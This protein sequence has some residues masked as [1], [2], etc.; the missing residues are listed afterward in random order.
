MRRFYLIAAA[1]IGIAVLCVSAS[2]QQ[3]SGDY[4]ETRSADVYTG[5]CVANGEVNLVGDQA[6]LGWKVNQGVWNGTRL[7]GL[8][9][10]AAVKANATL[11]D[12]YTNSYP[13]KAVLIVDNRANAAQRDALIS[14]AKRMGGELFHEVVRVEVA[15]IKMEVRH[16]EGHFAN[17]SLHAGT[18]A[19]IETRSLTKF[20]HLCGNES[21]FYPPLTDTVHAM[22]AVAEL[23]QYAG[24]DLGVSWKSSG[25]RSAFV[26][27]FA[28]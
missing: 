6:I 19:A 7:D 15:P 25:K 4:I 28:K 11:G 8:S 24:N 16:R 18:I 1:L 21:T 5:A 3:I 12:P 23:D 13:A 10:V 27:S 2:A 14:F 26:G 17:V 20:D 22:P 9:I